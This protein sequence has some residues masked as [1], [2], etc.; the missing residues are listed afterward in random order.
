[1]NQAF[2]RIDEHGL[3]IAP[4]LCPISC[5]ITCHS[6]RPAVETAVPDTMD[7]DEP[8]DVCWQSVASQA[9]PTSEPVGQPL[10]RCQ[11]PAPSLPFW[12]RQPEKMESRSLR[13]TDSEHATFQGASEVAVEGH[14]DMYLSAGALRENGIGDALWFM[15]LELNDA[16]AHLE[17]RLQ[18]PG[19][20]TGRTL[21]C[22][23]D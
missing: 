14:L 9:I 19:K 8:E 15:H 5:A 21:V 1:M 11:S 17:C 10:M 2:S 18:S 7:G 12:P 6:V 23:G 3:T 13:V 16:E 20:R 4:K 22:C